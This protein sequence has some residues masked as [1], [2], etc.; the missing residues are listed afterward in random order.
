MA[1]KNA[2]IFWCGG[3]THGSESD[4]ILQWLKK[5]REM[6]R[7]NSNKIKYVSVILIAFI[8]INISSL[9]L[10]QAEISNSSLLTLTNSARTEAGLSGLSLNSELQSAAQ[11]KAENMFKDQYFAHI[12]K[13][14]RN[15]WDF[16]KAAGY[17]YVYAGE[18]LAIGYDNTSE[19]QT[20]WMNSPTHR[21]NIVSPN[22][23]EIGFASV[24]GTYE[25]AQTTI[26]V[27]MFGSVESVQPIAQTKTVASAQNNVTTTPKNV[28]PSKVADTQN[29]DALKTSDQVKPEVIDNVD[30][31]GKI[32]NSFWLNVKNNFSDHFRIY[33]VTTTLIILGIAGYLMMRLKRNGKLI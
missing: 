15:P 1:A 4:I 3:L 29:T 7:V 22:F 2:A 25:G 14:G 33:V 20:A 28:T 5:E 8:L 19:L 27:E 16:I 21:A 26:V 9:G 13:D 32:S 30:N 6:N 24:N 31:A 18:N 12:S 11:A 17:N 23:R 10:A